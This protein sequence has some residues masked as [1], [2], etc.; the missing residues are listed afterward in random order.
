MR[1]AF[2]G[3]LVAGSLAAVLGGCQRVE[4]APAANCAQVA[5]TLTAFEVGNAATPEQRAPVVAKHKATCES[6]KTTA[7]EAACLAS[8]KDTWAA[9]A[10]LPRMFPPPAAG[11]A[12]TAGGP[13]NPACATL[14]ARMRDAV[15]TDVGSNNA[16]AAAQMAKI[17]PVVQTACEQDAWPASIT[18]CVTDTKSGDMPAFQACMNQLSQEHQSKLAQRLNTAM[19]EQ[20]APPAP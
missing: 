16:A 5:D 13:P 9:R 1:L 3:A 8:A 2:A 18:T 20:P 14:A 6:T 4:R 15:L 12:T 7:A 10:C 11:A 19:N 17:T